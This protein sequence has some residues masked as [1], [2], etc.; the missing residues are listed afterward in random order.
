MDECL[1]GGHDRDWSFVTKRELEHSLLTFSKISLWRLFLLIVE[2]SIFFVKDRF[3]PS[4]YCSFI[5]YGIRNWNEQ[6]D[7][8]QNKS[9][10]LHG[11]VS[12]CLWLH[13]RRARS[14]S[15]FSGH[16]S[17]LWTCHTLSIP[18]SFLLRRRA[19][20]RLALFLNGLW[21]VAVSCH[22]AP[23]KNACFPRL[24]SYFRFLKQDST[25]ST[26]AA[27]NRLVVQSSLDPCPFAWLVANSV[28]TGY[29]SFGCCLIY[30]GI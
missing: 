12:N 13:R 21:F 27:K 6:R 16:P 15:D 19:S 23:F 3:Q 22:W 11:R 7:G 17:C 24:T 10:S 5:L 1:A 4:P 2:A 26:T 30:S 14:I 29:S 25:T 28:C 8:E 9:V 18:S 20:S